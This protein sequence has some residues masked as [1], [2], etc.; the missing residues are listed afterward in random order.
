MLKNSVVGTLAIMPS[1]KLALLFTSVTHRIADLRQIP[2][3]R[4][5]VQLLIEQA[6]TPA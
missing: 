4:L 5:R 2:I 1:L 3:P 6:D